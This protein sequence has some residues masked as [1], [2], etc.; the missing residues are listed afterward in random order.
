M[1]LKVGYSTTIPVSAYGIKD[2]A[3]CEIEVEVENLSEFKEKWN[4]VKSIVD[5]SVKEKYPFLFQPQSSETLTQQPL[6]PNDKEIDE[7][8]QR[9][10]EE[11]K[12]KI[13]NASSKAAAGQILFDSKWKLN[14]ELKELVN[15]KD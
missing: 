2:N 1:K 15:G 11:M 3:W 8:N 7:A 6:Q 12:Q 13:K 10:L 5:A 14:K 9:E 4:E